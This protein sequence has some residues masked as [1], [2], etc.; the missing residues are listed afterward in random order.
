MSTEADRYHLTTA[1]EFQHWRDDRTSPAEPGS[2]GLYAL[3]SSIDHEPVYIGQS[4]N[5]PLRIVQ[6]RREKRKRFSYVLYY[7]EPDLVSRLRLEG[8]MILLHLPKYNRGLN[9]G[10]AAGKVW[11]IKW[12]KSGSTRK[13]GPR[14]K[15]SAR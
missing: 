6:H 4:S 9:L 7:H 8:V 2:A 1:A 5:I 11:E 3:M 14:S 10:F 15:T 12:A 13:K